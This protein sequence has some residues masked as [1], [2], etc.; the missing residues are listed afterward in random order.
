MKSIKNTTTA[1]LRVPL[2]LGKVLHLGPHRTG[3]IADPAAE[4]PPLAKLIEDGKIEI[5][6][7][8][9]DAAAAVASGTSAH[10][11]THGKGPKS[12]RRQSG[13]R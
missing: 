1:P 3:Q 8:G 10:A 2:P 4:H 5:V 11:S 9:A 13:D 6:A 12:N 7:E